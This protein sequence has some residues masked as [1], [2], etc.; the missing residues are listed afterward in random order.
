MRGLMLG[1]VAEY[2]LKKM[3]FEHKRISALVKDDDHDRKSKGDI[4]FAYRGRTFRVECKS[5]Q[6]NLIQKTKDVY[7]R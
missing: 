6:S 7:G 4:R 3:Y 5:L 2:K 1:Y